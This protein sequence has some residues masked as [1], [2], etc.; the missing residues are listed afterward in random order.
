MRGGEVCVKVSHT[1]DDGNEYE[2]EHSGCDTQSVGRNDRLCAQGLPDQEGDQC[3]IGQGCRPEQRETMW[4][5]QPDGS[6]LCKKPANQGQN[7]Q[8]MQSE[9]MRDT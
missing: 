1:D 7:L 2:P 3:Q 4:T 5:A 9:E 6:V 8:G